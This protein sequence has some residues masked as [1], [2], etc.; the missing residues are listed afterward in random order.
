MADSD[1]SISGCFNRID[2]ILAQSDNSFP[3]KEAIPSMDTLTHTNGCYVPCV[4]LFVDIRD[5]ST[6]TELHNR[7][8][9]AKI[10]RV[11]LSEVSAV[12]HSNGLHRQ[13]K[14]VGDC[15]QGIF[16]APRPNEN[17]SRVFTTV[18]RISS[19]VEVINK[20]LVKKNYTPIRVGIGLSYG[21]ALMIKAGFSG[22]GI[23]E[24]VWMGDVVNE[25]SALCDYGNKS[26]DFGDKELM[27]SDSVYQKLTSEQ[28][29]LVSWHTYRRCYTG[30]VQDER[31]R[32]AYRHIEE[33]R[34]RPRP[35][36][37]PPPAPSL[38]LISDPFPL[39]SSA[40]SAPNIGGLFANLTMKDLT[41][42]PD[43]PTGL[44]LI[45]F[46]NNFD[47]KK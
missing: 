9:L 8:V 10:Y 43:R 34:S 3:E 32:E 2:R 42:Q 37:T 44:G 12:M 25:A 16:T 26:P 18:Q 33:A 6:L 24:V 38:P 46:L 36:Y 47:S 28:K 21:N 7:P 23:N 11:F 30:D 14:I 19:I 39:F 17:I 13:V 29:A 20:K 5:S 45:D 22:S 35:A 4:A 15:V 1:F 31:I 40:P 27:L 41:T